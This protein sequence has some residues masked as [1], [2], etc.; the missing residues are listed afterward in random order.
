MDLLEKD[1]AELAA[2]LRAPDPESRT[3]AGWRVQAAAAEIMFD[4][5]PDRKDVVDVLRDG[6]HASN[7]NV[8]NWIAS[9]LG[10]RGPRAR[11]FVQD[12][13]RALGDPDERVRGSARR[14]L[15]GIPP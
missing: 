10:A 13:E 14:A 2:M 9:S 5:R 8:R 7:P 12:L 11:P 1:L 6:L 3:R 15:D 4:M